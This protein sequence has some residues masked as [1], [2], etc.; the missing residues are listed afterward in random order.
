MGLAG[1]SETTAAATTVFAA[2][3]VTQ[4][5]GQLNKIQPKQLDQLKSET[6]SVNISNKAIELSRSTISNKSTGRK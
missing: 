3:A 4:A 6:D 5:G 1:I 2:Q